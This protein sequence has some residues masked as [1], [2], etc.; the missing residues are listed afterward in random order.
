M[1]KTLLFP[2]SQPGLA[3]R[4]I[5]PPLGGASAVCIPTV[6]ARAQG[7]AQDLQGQGGGHTGGTGMASPTRVDHA[8]GTVGGYAIVL[9]WVPD[10]ITQDQSP[11]SS[12]PSSHCF[13][14]KL[15]GTC[16]LSMLGRSCLVAE[17]LHLPGQVDNSLQ[18]GALRATHLSCR[19]PYRSSW[20][21]YCT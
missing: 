20:T 9:L 11:S 18:S 13:M 7:P 10:L 14:A 3:F 4:C 16:A 5:S 12:Q 8:P 1:P 21:V 6:P 15:H 2:E 17:A 19:C